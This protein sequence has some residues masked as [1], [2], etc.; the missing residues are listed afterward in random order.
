MTLTCG[1][2]L[3]EEVGRVG[4]T[5]ETFGTHAAQRHA[6]SVGV[7]AGFTG[8]SA[9]R[10]ERAVVTQRAHAADACVH[11]LARTRA[12]DGAVVGSRA[13]TIHARLA[14]ISCI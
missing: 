4:Q 6:L 3:T 7:A 1:T 10:G 11:S 14:V 9:R 5:V 13:R 8:Q 12:V 2:A